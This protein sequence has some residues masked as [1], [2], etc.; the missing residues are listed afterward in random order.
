MSIIIILVET[1]TKY[2]HMKYRNVL[3]TVL[4]ANVAITTGPH[5]CSGDDGMNAG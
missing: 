4:L 3:E 5:T 2:R 1:G